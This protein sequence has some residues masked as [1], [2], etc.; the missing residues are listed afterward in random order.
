[1]L[2]TAST[3][4]FASQTR[5]LS[6]ELENADLVPVPSG[7]RAQA[8]G[9]DGRLLDGFWVKTHAGWC[10]RTAPSPAAASSLTVAEFLT[11]GYGLA[12]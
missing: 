2:V 11:K 6:P 8:L 9:G 3:A 1:M 5:S 10:V 12:G 4:A 7:V